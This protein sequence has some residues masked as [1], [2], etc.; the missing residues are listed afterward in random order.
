MY[1]T[2]IDIFIFG[3]KDDETSAILGIILRD[4]PVIFLTFIA[5]IFSG[6]CGWFN[7]KILCLNLP[8]LR[9]SLLLLYAYF[10]SL[11]C[12]MFWL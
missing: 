11:W 4:Y 5:L 7:T 9:L 6:F 12:F 3:L 2:N 1:K 10:F 8:P